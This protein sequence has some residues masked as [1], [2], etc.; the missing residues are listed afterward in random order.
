MSEIEP[1]KWKRLTPF[2]LLTL[3]ISMQFLKLVLMHLF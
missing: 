1:E 2:S 3:K